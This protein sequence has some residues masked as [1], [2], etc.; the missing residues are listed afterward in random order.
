M[1][2]NEISLTE[3]LIILSHWFMRKYH[4]GRAQHY[5]DPYR[6]QGRILSLLKMQP[7]ISQKELSYLLGIR[8][9]S[10][11]ELLTKL[12][13]NGCITRT[14]STEDRRAMEIKLTEK[15]ASMAESNEQ[16]LSKGLEEDEIFQCLT[17]EE[18]KNLAE[19]FDR[20]LNNIQEISG[21]NQMGFWGF[22]H[23]NHFRRDGHMRGS[24]RPG[25]GNREGRGGRGGMGGRGRRD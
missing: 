22:K 9:Q 1:Q 25:R 5:H 21:E 8:P 14:Q 23:H 12:E 6:G 11:G 10:L 3:R 2:T 13:Q 7:E 24:G 4:H 17:E 20:I 19:Y 16:T 18:K 15:G